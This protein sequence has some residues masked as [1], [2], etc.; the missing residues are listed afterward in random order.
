MT[1]SPNYS[2]ID[3]AVKTNVCIYHVIIETATRFREISS[4]IMNDAIFKGQLRFD[5]LTTF[6]WWIS[7][8]SGKRKTIST[9]FKSR[10]KK[11]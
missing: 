3:H 6:L 1:Y 11:S 4:T 9:E 2:I 7:Y 8:H 10:V 5:T